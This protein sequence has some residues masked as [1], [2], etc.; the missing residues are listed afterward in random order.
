MFESL[1][2]RAGD[3]LKGH[4]MCKGSLNFLTSHH[5][6]SLKKLDELRCFV[7]KLKFKW[8]DSR[9]LMSLNLLDELKLLDEVKLFES[10][11]LMSLKT[12]DEQA[13]VSKFKL[14]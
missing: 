9:E 5:S 8:L 4:F 6:M 2:L 13:E 10:Y 11:K 7:V 1:K 12:L 14:A 3:F